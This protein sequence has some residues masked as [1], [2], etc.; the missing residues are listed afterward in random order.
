MCH[1]KIVPFYRARNFLVLYENR[2]TLTIINRFKSHLTILLT[3]QSLSSQAPEFFFF[4]LFF[5]VDHSLF[6]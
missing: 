3:N 2:L 1:S 5:A 4:K 6:H